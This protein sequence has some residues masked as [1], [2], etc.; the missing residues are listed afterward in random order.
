[1]SRQLDT[2]KEDKGQYEAWIR[3]SNLQEYYVSSRGKGVN[4]TSRAGGSVAVVSA[5][6][7]LDRSKVTSS[8]ARKST[9]SSSRRD[10]GAE[11]YAEEVFLFDD[12]SHTALNEAER[13]EDHSID[14]GPAN[15]GSADESREDID[16]VDSSNHEARYDGNWSAAVLS[17]HVGNSTENNSTA[18][19]GN[20]LIRPNKDTS[21]DIVNLGTGT[22]QTIGMQ[23]TMNS[24]ASMAAVRHSGSIEEVQA[25]RQRT[26]FADQ[27]DINQ[28]QNSLDSKGNSDHRSALSS[29]ASGRVEVVA[30]DG[31]RTI[32]YRNGTTK[33]IYTDGSMFIHFSNGDTKLQ[34]PL[35]TCHR[36]MNLLEEQRRLLS[37]M[38]KGNGHDLDYMI[39]GSDY[40]L[41]GLREGEF[42]NTSVCHGKDGVEI[43][44]YYYEKAQT[45]H[46]SF[47]DGLEVY[48]FPNQQV[49]SFLEYAIY[50]Y[51]INTSR[52]FIYVA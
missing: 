39:G 47:P 29:N 52:R 24:T 13:Y 37:N 43:V 32:S 44:V 15:L 28:Q 8:S 7:R 51:I 11:T 42:Y 18:G 26:D 12:V 31:T 34:L 38:R 33:E 3:D 30:D 35:R 2:M 21:G 5:V 48:E 17:K 27:R 4:S 41:L 9:D 50:A 36:A 19:I 45:T 22:L 40:C 14:D 1:M 49:R 20:S 16:S 46:M 25:N 23:T 6:G 10:K